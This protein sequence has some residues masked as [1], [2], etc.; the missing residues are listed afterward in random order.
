MKKITLLLILV[1]SLLI[2]SPSSVF[3]S[4]EEYGPVGIVQ[5]WGLEKIPEGYLKADG[6]E[7]SRATYSKLFAIIGTHY[8]AGD[9]STTFNLPDLTGKAA[10]GLNINDNDFSNLGKTGGTKTETLS[11]DQMPSH[12]HIQNAHTHIQESHTHAQRE[13]THIQEAHTHTQNSHNH[14][15]NSHT[16]TQNAHGHATVSGYSYSVFKGTRSTEVV[17]KI[18]GS[19]HVMTQIAESGSW[20]GSTVVNYTTASNVATTATNQYATATNQNTVA[21]NNYTTATNQYTTAE[22][23]STI[24]VNQNTGGSQAHTN[25][26][27]YQVLQ[28]IIKYE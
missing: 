21:E 11:V 15:Q 27:P 18:S 26:Q 8:G 20:S 7:V 28:Y 10:V 1:G 24:A 5:V 4:T 14:S 12:T 13:H 25:L 9:G 2:G 16:H 23:N 19:T 17:G 3:A 6:R 22:N